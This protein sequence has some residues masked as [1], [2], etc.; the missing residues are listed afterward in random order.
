MVVRALETGVSS[1]RHGDPW[2]AALLGG[3][4]KARALTGE[5]DSVAKWPGVV[6]GGWGVTPNAQSWKRH[7]GKA[8]HLGIQAGWEQVTLA[9]P[10]TT[11][12]WRVP[13]L[14]LAAPLGET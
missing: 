14:P 10:G 6:T 11:A 13:P 9:G 8:C 7:R 12:G 4:I 1:S 2:D 3:E 5:G